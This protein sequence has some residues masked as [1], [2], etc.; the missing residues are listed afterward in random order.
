MSN[1]GNVIAV[2]YL[3]I[4]SFPPVCC[5]FEVAFYANRFVDNLELVVKG[6][7][8]RGEMK[9]APIRNVHVGVTNLA[10]A[11]MTLAL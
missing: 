8:V 1:Y 2:V 9:R 11:D 6:G 7:R 3:L 5:C 10:R 4:F